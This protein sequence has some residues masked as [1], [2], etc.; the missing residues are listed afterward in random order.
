MPLRRFVSPRLGQAQ[1]LAFVAAGQ[2]WVRLDDASGRLIAY[3]SR[4]GGD[5]S[6]ASAL[7]ASLCERLTSEPASHRGAYTTEDLGQASRVF[8]E[9]WRLWP[10]NPIPLRD[11]V[12]S[13][14]FKSAYED[15][16]RENLDQTDTA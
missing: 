6:Q 4:E 12:S 13:P 5:L 2:A 3:W 8:I 10:Y 16:N 15:A 11:V 7:V 1:F 14:A 9:G